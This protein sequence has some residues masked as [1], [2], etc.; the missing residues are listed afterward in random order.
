MAKATG[1]GKRSTNFLL[2]CNISALQSTV[3]PE[4]RIGQQC[5][6][7]VLEQR[8]IGQGIADVVEAVG[9]KALLQ[10]LQF[11]V[12]GEV[13]LAIAGDYAVEDAQ[14]SGDALGQDAIGPGGQVELTASRMLV[15]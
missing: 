5:P 15:P 11:V 14:V 13:D 7:G 4:I 9:G 12:A 3:Q 6:L 8:Q 10:M 1:A 2:T